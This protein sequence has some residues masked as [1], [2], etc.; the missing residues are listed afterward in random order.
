MAEW[1]VRYFAEC[2]WPLINHGWI[3]GDSNVPALQETAFTRFPLYLQL[4]RVKFTEAPRLA[5]QVTAI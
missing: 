5:F 4:L 3:E 1:L 2:Q